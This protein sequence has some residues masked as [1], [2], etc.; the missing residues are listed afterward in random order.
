MASRWWSKAITG[1][2]P[3]SAID[4]PAY[5]VNPSTIAPVLIA[6][7]AKIRIYSAK[8]QGSGV[9]EFRWR[10][11]S[12]YRNRRASLS[13][14]FEPGEIVMEIVVPPAAAEPEGR[15]LR[16]SPES[17]V[18]LAA[19]HATV[20][21]EMNGDTVSSARVVLGHV[22]PV[23]WLS[24]DAAQALAGKAV[25]EESAKAAAEAALAQAKPLQPE[26]VQNH[27][28]QDGGEAR[29][30]EYAADPPEVRREC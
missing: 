4:G 19:R 1:T 22:A 7:G 30:S 6:Y 11:F 16:G 8:T 21:L 25:T 5:F 17:S 13:T 23:P 18:R 28:R 24:I 9:R 26:Q 12:S 15:N 29:D 27:A 2:L 3:S 14:T 20:A 10:S